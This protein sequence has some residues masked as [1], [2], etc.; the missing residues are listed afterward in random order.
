MI[1]H[2]LER[3]TTAFFSGPPIECCGVVFDI[4]VEN[5]SIVKWCYLEKTMNKYE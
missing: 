1:F 3:N 5:Q 4:N 2:I